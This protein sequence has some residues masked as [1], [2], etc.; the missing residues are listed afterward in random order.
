M[1]LLAW[2]LLALQAAG[3]TWQS[4]SLSFA[5]S[6][7]TVPVRG[8]AT[9]VVMNPNGRFAYVLSTGKT[10][11][12]GSSLNVVDLNDREVVKVIR[13]GQVGKGIAISLNGKR[14]YVI[15]DAEH[16]Q[17]G[18]ASLAESDSGTLVAFDTTS[19]TIVGRTRFKAAMTQGIAPSPTGKAVYVAGPGA[20]PE[21]ASTIFAVDTA[22][23]RVVRRIRV[24][25]MPGSE[26][27][28][29]SRTGDLLYAASA[30]GAGSGYSKGHGMA[31]DVVSLVRHAVV[32]RTV[33]THAFTDLVT[34]PAKPDAYASVDGGAPQTALWSLE[35][36]GRTGGIVARRRIGAGSFGAAVTASGTFLYLGVETIGIAVLDAATLKQV[37]VIPRD[38]LG[39]PVP[40]PLGVTAKGRR[41]CVLDGRDFLSRGAD[42]IW[43]LDVNRT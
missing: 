32:K 40:G 14:V 11:S 34:D 3:G 36:I 39:L 41:I 8:I 25:T 2:V 24:G 20:T 37:A 42:K 12:K 4:T 13:L 43:I 17:G 7:K 35:V 16:V 6:Y 21:S 1:L 33:G 15:A 28:A 38:G 23:F 22:T 10:P 26:F 31:L 9:N 5:L 30:W 19:M 27:M 18:T 29:I